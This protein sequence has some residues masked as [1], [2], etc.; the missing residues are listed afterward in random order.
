M[1]PTFAFEDYARF[2]PFSYAK[3]EV[4]DLATYIRRHHGEEGEVEAWLGKF[5][6][7]GVS[8]LTGQLLMTL[9]EAIAESFSYQRR[10]ARGT[11]TPSETLRRQN[12]TCRDLALLMMEAA[13][14]LG[15]A[16]LCHGIRLRAGPRRTDTAGRWLDS[17]VVPNLLA[18]VRLD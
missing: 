15:F 1:P 9:N 2:H 7:K 17:R 18:G 16:A 10:S 5:L 12:G 4:P 11:Q 14:S 3:E 6:S 13:R 8:Q